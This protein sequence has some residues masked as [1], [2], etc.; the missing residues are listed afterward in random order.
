MRK[1]PIRAAFTLMEVLLVLVILVILASAVALPLFNVQSKAFDKAARSAIGSLEGAA[2]QY[3]M[4]LNRF[5]TTSQGLE[6][7]VA[8]PSDLPNPAKWQGPYI[9]K[10][11]LPV[12]PW[13]QPYQYRYPGTHNGSTMP[14][15]WSVGADGADGTED[16]IGNWQ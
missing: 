1:R 10:G 15:I 14:D 5:P 13:D 2:Q 11:R 16:D 7:L 4:E 6:A 8:P 3:A 9:A 12:D